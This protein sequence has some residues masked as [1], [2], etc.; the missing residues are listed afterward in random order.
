MQALFILVQHLTFHRR[1]IGRQQNSAIPLSS[2]LGLAVVAMTSNPVL[3]QRQTTWLIRVY[4][5]SPSACVTR[6]IAPTSDAPLLWIQQRY[7]LVISPAQSDRIL[8]LLQEQEE[9]YKSLLTL[10]T[11][12][13]EVIVDGTAAKDVYAYALNYIREKHPNL[14]KNFPKNIGFA[15]GLEFRDSSYVLNA[16]N[17]RRLKSNMV[18]NLALGLEKLDEGNGKT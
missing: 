5:S 6:D 17:T 18:F 16:K 7:E 8:T 14:E 2:N 1:L 15:M 3:S 4:F 10:Q 11:S 9:L 13:L 12:L